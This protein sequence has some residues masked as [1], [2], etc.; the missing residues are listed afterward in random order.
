MILI[1]IWW[2][3]KLGRLAASK[4]E[5]QKFDGE[6]FNLRKLNG[7]EVRKQYPIEIRKRFAA[8]EN[9]SDGKD[10]N[11]AW[12]NIKKNIKTSAKVSLGLHELKQHKPWFDEKCLGFLDQGRRLKCSGNRIQ[13]RAMQII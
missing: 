12:E 9:F 1:T 2:L 13:T 8:L 7:L 3:Q 6:R 10:I 11:R 5:A 4:Q